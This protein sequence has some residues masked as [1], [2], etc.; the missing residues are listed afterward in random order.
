MSK[1]AGI[2]ALDRVDAFL[3]SPAKWHKGN[4][5]NAQDTAWCLMG[6]CYEAGC[7]DALQPLYREIRDRYNTTL[8]EWN[9]ADERTFA[10]VKNLIAE[11]RAR[12]AKQSSI[13]ERQ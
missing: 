9:D 7:P 6:A 12:I 2:S 4:L 1:K 3:D 11:T 13:G 5:S 10:D 8:V